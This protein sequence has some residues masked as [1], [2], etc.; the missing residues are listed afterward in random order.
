MDALQT[1]LL[2]DHRSK[3]ESKF[4]NE[5]CNLQM[6]FCICNSE[7]LDDIFVDELLEHLLER[8]WGLSFC[9]GNSSLSGFD[10]IGEFF[11]LLEL[12]NARELGWILEQL[13]DVIDF[14]DSAFIQNL[15]GF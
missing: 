2:S 5:L 10:L 7:C 3:L 9:Q 12:Q 1:D 15:R 4:K 14:G 8:L 6:Y 13:I 11:E